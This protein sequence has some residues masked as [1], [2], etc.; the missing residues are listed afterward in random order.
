MNQNILGSQKKKRYDENLVDKVNKQ[1]AEAEKKVEDKKVVKSKKGL[2][3][4]KPENLSILHF[5]EYLNQRSKWETDQQNYY[6]NSTCQVTEFKIRLEGSGNCYEWESDNYHTA[7]IYSDQPTGKYLF[8]KSEPG[9]SIAA[10][11]YWGKYKDG[12]GFVIRSENESVTWLC[13]DYIANH[14]KDWAKEGIVLKLLT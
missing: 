1:F 9:E 13:M 2:V 4:K 12:H 11:I 14:E 5:L 6:S 10:K 7:I 3:I 8:R